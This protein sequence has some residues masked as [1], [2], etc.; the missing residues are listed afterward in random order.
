MKRS[1]LVV[2][3]DKDMRQL[4]ALYLSSNDFEII[5][6][7]DLFG[8]DLQLMPDLILM[9][10]KLVNSTGKANCSILKNNKYTS[11]IPVIIMSA[12][13][14]RDE[15]LAAGADAF[16]AKPFLLEDLLQIINKCLSHQ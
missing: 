8:A 1:I 6:N 14:V 15:S 16:I 4:L 7:D 13:P 5:E 11:H 9:D 12:S 10:N 3:D 2:E